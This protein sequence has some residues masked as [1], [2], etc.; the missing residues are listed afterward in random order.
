MSAMARRC[1]QARGIEPTTSAS[2]PAAWP[3][4]ISRGTSCLPNGPSWTLLSSGCCSR[5]PASLVYCSSARPVQDT[6]TVWLTKECRQ[7]LDGLRCHACR[8]GLAVPDLV[9]L[10]LLRPRTGRRGGVG[11][12]GTRP[13]PRAGE[14]RPRS[15]AGGGAPGHAGEARTWRGR[16][17]G[18]LRQA[19][20]P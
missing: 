20:R 18:A 10:L 19:L 8:Q 3:V 5:R 15:A 13:V 9:V 17:A 12:P 16:L 7:K 1:H 14:A 2:W 11:A 6:F 4:E